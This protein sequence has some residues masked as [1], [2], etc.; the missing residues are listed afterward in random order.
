[1]TEGIDQETYKRLAAERIT[2]TEIKGFDQLTIVSQRAINGQLAYMWRKPD[3]PLR[4]INI[5]PYGDKAPDY[6][7]DADL[8]APTVNLSLGPN[9]QMVIFNLNV[10]VGLGYP[11]YHTEFTCSRIF[12]TL[13]S[14]VRLVG[15]MA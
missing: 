11:S 1:M 7:F 8:S 3:S 15:M 13:H 5:R 6:F 10:K 4:K 14:L 12:F 2:S 9:K